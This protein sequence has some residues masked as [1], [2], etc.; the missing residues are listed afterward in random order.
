M[1]S[2]LNKI[3]FNYFIE[4]EPPPNMA[5]LFNAL[6]ASFASLF[7]ASLIGKSSSTSPGALHVHT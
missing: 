5:K 6:H 4:Q 2:F 3:N 7:L 1:A